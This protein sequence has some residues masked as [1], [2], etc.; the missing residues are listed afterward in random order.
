MTRRLL[1]APIAALALCACALPPAAAAGPSPASIK[2]PAFDR[3]TVDEALERLRAFEG[4]ADSAIL[5]A[6]EGALNRARATRGASERPAAARDLNERL[7]AQAPQW[8]ERLEEARAERGQLD[9]QIALLRLE[10]RQ[11]AHGLPASAMEG[12]SD[13]EIDELIDSLEIIRDQAQGAQREIEATLA[14]L[15]IAQTALR[16]LP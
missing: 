16:G 11:R 6:L 2:E 15:D 8:R 9:D 4:R 13:A 12:A 1:L 5:R 7:G 10:Q 3:M 14:A